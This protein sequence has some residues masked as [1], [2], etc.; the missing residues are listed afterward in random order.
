MPGGGRAAVPGGVDDPRLADDVGVLL[1]LAPDLERGHRH[2]AA[3][4]ELLRA[5][6]ERIDR[7]LRLA[8]GPVGG[9]HAGPALDHRCLLDLLRAGEDLLEG[10][11]LRGGTLLERQQPLA[12]LGGFV[13][14]R[15]G[16]IAAVHL[17]DLPT[18]EASL[19]ADAV[20]PPD[21]AHDEHP[22]EQAGER[23][24][25]AGAEA[26]VGGQQQEHRAH[27]H[28][29]AHPDDQQAADEDAEVQAVDGDEGTHWACASSGV[30][31]LNT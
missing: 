8:P 15:R 22:A 21:G 16:E 1:L 20:D 5:E 18:G 6:Q 23:Q 11:G 12:Q 3:G 13:E 2:V 24:E 17:D 10:G 19:V 4:L 26:A 14:L 25:H 29:D 27:E 9:Q 7:G 30:V 31:G 28:G